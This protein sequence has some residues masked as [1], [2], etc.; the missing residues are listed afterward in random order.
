M[1][2]TNYRAVEKRER[3]DSFTGTG[4]EKGAKEKYGNT[5]NLSIWGLKFAGF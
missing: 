4:P 5:K 3:R 1:G 2:I